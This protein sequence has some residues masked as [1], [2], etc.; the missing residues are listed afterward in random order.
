MTMIFEVEDLS[1]ASPATVSRCGMVYMEPVALGIQPLIDSWYKTIPAAFL[2]RKTF[3][4]TIKNMIDTYA[5]KLLDFVRKN[6]KELVTSIANNLISSTMRIMNSFFEPF[7]ET[8]LNK[9]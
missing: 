5:T 2:A 9:V 3:L 7:I 4:P 1:V 6:C 8:E